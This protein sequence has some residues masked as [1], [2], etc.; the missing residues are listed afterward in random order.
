MH[1]VPS[2]N[3]C[4]YFSEWCI[5]EICSPLCPPQQGDKIPSAD[6]LSKIF[7]KRILESVK[8]PAKSVSKFTLN[9]SVFSITI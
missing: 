8:T 7:L 4:S 2:F 1:K 9:G 5:S 3:C 6:E